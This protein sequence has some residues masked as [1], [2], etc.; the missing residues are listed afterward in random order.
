MTKIFNFAY[1]MFLLLVLFS[2]ATEVRG[3]KNFYLT[4]LMK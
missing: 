3:G 1:A 4:I 2:I